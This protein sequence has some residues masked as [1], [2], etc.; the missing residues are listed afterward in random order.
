MDN[1]GLLRRVILPMLLVLIM[2]ACKQKQEYVLF[3]NVDKTLFEEAEVYIVNG[4]DWK[5]KLDS[6][7]VR[8]G[9]FR[10]QGEVK[11]PIIATV[12]VKNQSG[13]RL[14]MNCVLEKGVIEMDFSEN[15]I[16]GTPQNEALQELNTACDT[17]VD[18]LEMLYSQYMTAT[19]EEERNAVE[20]KYDS[21]NALY[22][23][24][25]M[26]VA[27]CTYNANKDNILGAYT[28]YKVIESGYQ[29][30]TITS[31]VVDSLMKDATPIVS[32]F[33]LTKNLVDVIRNTEKTS[34]GKHYTDLQ[35]LEGKELVATTL[36]KHIDGKVALI[37]FWA[38]WC[39]PCRDEI[40][41]IAKIYAKYADKGLVVIGLNVWDKPENQRKT[42]ETMK[43]SWIQLS[44]TTNNATNV[45]GIAG[46]PQIMVIDD[47]GTILARNLRG[48]EIEKVVIEALR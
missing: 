45:Y 6:S 4:E 48:E 9:W 27:L 20:Q 15:V 26:K 22:N 31:Y 21:V 47:D 46:I 17:E 16:S 39:R 28:M 13:K 30:G 38:S 33:S 32:E 34:E 5:I 42:I 1:I 24:K 43:M 7:V 25:Y 29:S 8:N 19:T 36:S 2:G 40:V 14:T 11:H 44:D 18:I 37:D 41:N 3:G 23:D 10:M 35:L 12:I